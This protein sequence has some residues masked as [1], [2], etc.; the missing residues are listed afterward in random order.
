MNLTKGL[1]VYMNIE[2]NKDSN[3]LL[4]D[5][6][7]VCMQ[8]DLQQE[9]N[10]NLLEKLINKSLIVTIERRDEKYI[11][12]EDFKIS[13]EIMHWNYE[14][15]QNYHIYVGDRESFLSEWIKIE[16]N[17]FFCY[18]VQDAKKA[19][20]VFVRN[21]LYMFKDKYKECQRMEYNVLGVTIITFNQYV[22]SY[23]ENAMYRKY[24]L[25]KI[26]SSNFANSSAYMGSKKKIVGFIIE[27]LWPHVESDSVILDIMCGSG[28]VS[29]ALAQINYLYASDAQLFCRLLAKIQ[30]AGFN[31]KKAL[32]TL[33]ELYI[34]YKRNLSCL[35]NERKM[36]LD[37]EKNVFHMDINKPNLV[38][39]KYKEYIATVD[40][41]SSTEDTSEEILKKIQLYKGDNRAF[42]YCLFTYYFANIYFGLEQCM[43]IDSIRYALDKL[44]DKEVKDWG[45]GVLIVTVSSIASNHA[46]HFA[47][48]K[49][50]DEKS[51]VDVIEKRKKSAWLEFSKRLLAIAEE[52]ER[53]EY[54]IKVIEGP[55]ENALE[56]VANAHP[57]NLIVYLDAP[58][59]R[60]EYSRFYHVLETV[61]LYD[62]PASERKG[63]LRSKLNGERFKTEFF[64]KNTQVVEQYLKKVIV[65][66]LK[67]SK[68]CVWSY[69]NNAVASIP[70]VV[71]EV[72]REVS[73]KIYF[74]SIPHKH[75]SQRRKDKTRER[76]SLV[77]IEYCIVFVKE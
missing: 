60:D 63:R 46:G 30:G 36:Q 9:F 26:K 40:L 45:L 32:E 3:F 55:W 44:D 25:D 21:I 76:S 41:Y 24:R 23:I 20:P 8:N 35:Q 33:N 11:Y 2:K 61:A 64:S 67:V 16:K 62:Y 34:H 52:S 27:S 43:Q 68:V 38:F 29:N 54:N 66:I 10:L 75:N 73:C 1:V 50:V 28:A 22:A 15:S 70:K 47:Q 65:S 4:L 18:P 56:Q 14:L 59:K 71:D 77:V 13:K 53:Y 17:T 12:K 51:I 57:S 72:R 19:A 39:E 49:R 69:S 48:P 6:F 74:Y 5:D 37:L 31:E 58:Y 7:V 42:P